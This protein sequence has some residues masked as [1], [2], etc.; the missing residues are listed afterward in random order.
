MSSGALLKVNASKTFEH[1]AREAAQIFG[2]SSVVREG[3]GA[4]VERL[5]EDDL[6][7]V[8]PEPAISIPLGTTWHC[9]LDNCKRATVYPLPPVDPGAH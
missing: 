2:G 1:C 8:H 9:F 6:H 7:A 3:R 5:C 4:R